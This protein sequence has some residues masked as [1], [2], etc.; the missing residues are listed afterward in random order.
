MGSKTEETRRIHSLFGE[1]AVM[2]VEKIRTEMDLLFIYKNP[3][4]WYFFR[5]YESNDKNFM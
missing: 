4:F 3:E 2:K 5:Y 1:D